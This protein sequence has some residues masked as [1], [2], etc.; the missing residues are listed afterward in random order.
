MIR[1]L[2]YICFL[3][4]LCTNS[5]GQK[6]YYSFRNL[7]T[8]NSLSQN[9][10]IAIGQDKLGQMWFA[11]R[12]G[13]NKYD[14]TTF[15][16]YRNNPQDSTTISNSDI[17]SI[18][19]DKD[20][21]L[22]IG[23][24]NG[25]NKYDPI[26]D[27]FSRY[28]HHSTKNSISNNTIKSITEI[29]NELW[30]GT[31]KG[32]NVFNKKTKHF[33]SYFNSLT[34]SLTISSSNISKI[35]K[36]KDGEIF[37]GTSEGVCMVMVN[38]K[39]GL[40]FKRVKTKS[41]NLSAS[42]FVKDLIEYKNGDILI[43]TEGNGL[44]RLNIKTKLITEANFKGSIID[45]DIRTFCIDKQDN[46]WLG[47]YDGLYT[48]KNKKIS[49]VHSLSNKDVGLKKIKSLYTDNNGSVWIGTYYRGVY[50]YDK[51]NENFRKIN[52]ESGSVKLK[53][54]VIGALVSDPLGNIY[55]GTEGSGV[56]IFNKTTNETKHLNSDNSPLS[57]NN[58]KSLLLVK[59]EL[60]IGTFNC[61]IY[62]YNID[63][64]NFKTKKIAS[65]LLEFLS[66]SSIYS[67]EQES[68][69]IFWIG[70]FGQGLIRYDV[71][72]RSYKIIKNGNDKNSLSNNNIRSILVDSEQQVWVATQN[73]LNKFN[74][75]FENTPQITH[76]FYDAKIDSGIDILVVYEDS[77]KNI[78]VGTKAHGLYKLDN[79]KFKKVILNDD[80]NDIVFSIH[81]ILEDANNT[82]W[83]SSNRGILSYNPKT[84]KTKIYDL[85]DGLVSKEYNNNVSLRIPPQTLYFGGSRGV[86][87]F[88]PQKIKF[89][90]H[91]PQVIIN[92]FKVK[93]KSIKIG[94]K[95]GI[96]SKAISYTD[97]LKLDYDK[98]NFSI[99]FSIPSF[100]SPSKN[101]YKHRLVGLDDQ[102][103]KT[104]RSSINYTIQK[105]G[106]YIFEV[107]GRNNDGI[108]NINPTFLKIT[109]LPAP[110]RSWW[111]FVIYGVFLIVTILGFISFLKSKEK[112]KHELE[113]EH[114]ENTQKEESHKLKLQF[115]TNISHE[116]RTPLTLILGPLQQLL[117]DY[118]GS[119]KMYK[120]LLII[121]NNANYLLQLINRLL[122]FRKLEKKQLK[123]QAAE[124]DIVSFLREISLSFSEFAITG[125]YNYT[126]ETSHEKLLVYYDKI[127][128]EQVFYNLISNAFRYT[129]KG[130]LISI[131]VSKDKKNL[132][133]KIKDTGIGINEEY[134]DK[135]FDRFFKVPTLN[136]PQENYNKGTG[137]GL[138][139]ARGIIQLHHGHI[140][141]KNRKQLGTI[142]TV[143]IP[144]GRNHLADDEILDNL[145]L[146]EDI[147]IYN[148]QLREIQENS[149][150]KID[151]LILEKDK[152]LVLIV[153]DNNEL[154]SF[155]ENF[156]KD[157]YN[158]KEAENGK[159]ALEMVL[160]YNP[161]LVIS[162]IVMPEMVGT[163]L[164]L[165]IKENIKTSHIPVILLTSRSSLMY[166][167]EGLE[168]GA[169]DY[170]SK[171]FNLKEF[172][173]RVHNILESS[174]R[175]KIKFQSED[176]LTPGDITLT[177]ID[178]TLL[179]KA[180]E[181][182]ELNI[183][184]EQFDIPFFC[185]EL[186][187]SR[188][189]L[190]TKIK[191]WTDFTPNGF[192][193]E[194][195]MKRAVQ[196]L[197]QNKINIS[198]IS[199]KVGFKNPKY[200]SKCFQKKYG[201]TPTQF[202]N[203]FIEN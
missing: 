158:I 161:D 27:T 123:L 124:D 34:D 17:S 66:Q 168:S 105:P 20:G 21:D 175:L 121:E 91:T 72:N 33:N 114:I 99:F 98:A 81:S 67:I 29:D 160:K 169:D 181:I 37:I 153:E 141:V 41:K 100:I 36:T 107:F 198:Q 180:M 85:T 108:W 117:E 1:T 151:N 184:N 189:M 202:R 12:D 148:F 125:D 119:S 11:T 31:S 188:T 199:Y 40:K 63:T 3:F 118:T 8:S 28:T 133:V 86:T 93:N 26:T 5:Y 22:W 87:Y 49:K 102:W 24:Y 145:N 75:E 197:E 170:I 6:D 163:E 196:L 69:N 194:I 115:F 144:F 110:W 70:T 84:K 182:V 92:D 142:F 157:T 51:S 156:L 89:N 38:N 82:L 137:I 128:L 19:I 190:F 9:S 146:S 4:L 174:K 116:F 154:R 45:K 39:D 138:S 130:G 140:T 48:L 77:Q 18:I 7:N 143:T 103:T 164:C 104:T 83:L 42:F 166:R 177:S 109:V 25:L 112:L 57:C 162:D 122:T 23:T 149:D 58:I 200:F 97:E 78:W 60:W 68:S 44:Y 186:G 165:K 52:L 113:L 185:Q 59:N 155:L 183:A 150:K 62:I 132:I 43:A 76:F 14:G 50:L 173:L 129:P 187:V 56:T 61:G 134:V 192:I 53:N 101:S 71:K 139:I 79:N 94:A 193:Q 201:L 172:K 135:I 74:L 30:I 95:D 120:K 46:L 65:K 96:L 10:V 167:H 176:Y 90:I 2:S 195:R 203:K 127:K 152:P 171:P 73:G 131:D 55:Y 16:V 64:K 191:A 136:E 88:D 106:D 35:L 111:A 47:T 159:V 13:L 147:S 126:F 80:S 54:Q 32:L 15:K 179:K 178:E